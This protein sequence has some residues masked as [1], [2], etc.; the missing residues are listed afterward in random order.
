M[1]KAA[2]STVG[3]DV[4]RNKPS[5][6]GLLGGGIIEEKNAMAHREKLARPAPKTNDF[7]QFKFKIKRGTMIHSWRVFRTTAPIILILMASLGSS[8]AAMCK[9]KDGKK[10]TVQVLDTFSIVNNLSPTIK[11]IGKEKK[12]Y[13]V[14]KETIDY[15]VLGDDTIYFKNFKGTKCVAGSLKDTVIKPISNFPKKDNIVIEVSS[16]NN[17]LKFMADNLRNLIVERVMETDR[18]KA[19]YLSLPIDKKDNC[20]IV[21]TK[22]MNLKTSGELN[23]FAIGFMFGLAGMA[24]SMASTQ[25][26]IGVKT[27]LINAENDEQLGYSAFASTTSRGTSTGSIPYQSIICIADAISSYATYPLLSKGIDK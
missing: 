25:G 24:A 5:K 2:R 15:I 17:D 27:E 18:Y 26:T 23:G 1:R 3:R 6:N 20:L 4:V 10:G 22:L 8:Y 13:N 14:P 16:D 7:K 21:R 11:L 12:P 19:I 9:F